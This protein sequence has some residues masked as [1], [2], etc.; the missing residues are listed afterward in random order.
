MMWTWMRARLREASR[1]TWQ[2]GWNERRAWEFREGL[3]HLFVSLSSLTFI[4]S[5][6]Y[7]PPAPPPLFVSLS[8]PTFSLGEDNFVIAFVVLILA[9]QIKTIRRN[10]REMR[11][12]ALT[13]A[14]VA[15]TALTSFVFAQDGSISGPGSSSQAANYTCDPNQCKLP[16]CRCASTSIPGDIPHDQTPMFLVF[17]AC[18][19]PI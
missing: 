1:G 5:Y 6:L 2:R 9:R 10:T 18:V 12:F 8:P 19:L 15:L 4:S 14:A 3:R 11:L 7:P 17:T 16:T 13:T